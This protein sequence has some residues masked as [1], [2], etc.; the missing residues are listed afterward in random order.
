MALSS[1]EISGKGG[2]LLLM[3]A[4]ASRKSIRTLQGQYPEITNWE[5]ILKLPL[6]DNVTILTPPPEAFVNDTE[7]LL[8]LEPFIHRMKYKKEFY[9]VLVRGRCQ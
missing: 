1:G 6:R 7:R 3:T 2:K 9:L 5:L 4:T 8:E